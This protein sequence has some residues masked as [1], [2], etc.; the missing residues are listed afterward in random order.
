[1]GTDPPT[2]RLGRASRRRHVSGA[3]QVAGRR[4]ESRGGEQ[5]PA[6]S[7]AG[8]I[9]EPYKRYRGAPGAAAQGPRPRKAG[10]CRLTVLPGP[11][12]PAPIGPA[13]RRSPS[14]VISCGSA[15][16]GRRWRRWGNLCGWRGVSARRPVPR[17]AEGVGGVPCPSRGG[18]AAQARRLGARLSLALAPVT[19]DIAAPG[20]R[21][22]ACSLLTLILRPLLCPL[23][24]S[25]GTAHVDTT[26]PRSQTGAAHALPS[27]HGGRGVQSPVN[28]GRKHHTPSLPRLTTRIACICSR[29]QCPHLHPL[30]G[31]FPQNPLLFMHRLGHY[32]SLTFVL[33]CFLA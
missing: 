16:K 15:G 22:G 30:T 1:M 12:L 32:Y 33:E 29:T 27:W 20:L 4:L 7:G 25:R 6:T 3:L 23:R 8:S 28:P 18:K 14:V 5:G 26:C 2:L 11:A 17:R 21:V 19:V 10:G 13:P 24:L 31:T 9:P